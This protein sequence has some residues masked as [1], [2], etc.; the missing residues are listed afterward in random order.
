MTG[1]VERKDLAD[2]FF[3]LKTNLMPNVVKLF[4]VFLNLNLKAH[5]GIL[6]TLFLNRNA[7]TQKRFILTKKLKSNFFFNFYS[8]VSHTDLT[9][10]AYKKSKLIS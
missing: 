8:A 5:F 9:S 7:K 1:N 2:G 10:D 4:V 6:I 3:L